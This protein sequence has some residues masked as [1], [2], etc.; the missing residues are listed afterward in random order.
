VIRRAA[1]PHHHAARRRRLVGHGY[2]S[3]LGPGLVTGAADDD[4]SGIGTYSQVGA[5]YGLAF[6]WTTVWVAPM[7]AAVQESAARLGLATGKGLATLIRER[8]SRPVLYGALAL[9]VAANTINIAADLGSMAAATRLVIDLPEALLVAF[10][11]G[12][13]AA[14]S[15][16]LPYHRYARVLRWL[17]LSLLAYP[18]VLT[19]VDVD[20]GEVLAHAFV[21]SF[22]GGAGGIAA[23]I[24]VFGTTVSP[25]LF[26]WQASEE[27]EEES[28]QGA[29]GKP[30]TPDHVTAMRIDVIGGMLSAVTIAFIIIVVTASTLHRSG[31]TTVST[32]EQAASALEPVAGNLAGFIFAVGI[33]GLGLLAVPVLAGSTAYA[34]SEA[35]GWHEGLSRTF[36]QAKGFYLV[37]GGSMVAGLTLVFA[38]LDP[39][40]GLY[41][42]A[43]FNGLAAPPLILLVLILGRDAHTVGE[44][45]SGRLSTSLLVITIVVSV[46]APIAYLVY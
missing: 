19:M 40:R 1:R 20:W 31:I 37:L 14:L 2:F 42:A 32:A 3:R 17:A 9:T 44:H 29:V 11:T 13:L 27:V 4:P 38:G 16:A 28:E 39:I 8:F 25:Y 41:Y 34:L 21:P 35:F 22:V 12:L 36:K 7:A 18:I 23:L 6:L 15:I 24:A 10:F 45:R 5:A 46:A 26:F 43:I 30:L 33:V